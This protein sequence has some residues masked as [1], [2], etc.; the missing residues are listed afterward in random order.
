[1][2]GAAEMVKARRGH[3][4]THV[5]EMPVTPR[6]PRILLTSFRSKVLRP[7]C[8]RSATARTTS[9]TMISA[10]FRSFSTSAFHAF[11]SFA[12]KPSAGLKYS[13]ASLMS[14]TSTYCG[15]PSQS[16]RR[17]DI[18]DGRKRERFDS[19]STPPS[20]SPSVRRSFVCFFAPDMVDRENCETLAGATGGV[21]MEARAGARGCRTGETRMRGRR[22]RAL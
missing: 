1:M 22:R 19:A 18:F 2:E 14:F 5:V 15:S 3:K 4:C 6:C 13:V 11:S 8:A 17:S 10:S 12:R 9:F 20:S 7:V 16:A 21:E